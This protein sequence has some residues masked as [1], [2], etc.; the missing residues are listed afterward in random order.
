M[1][2]LSNEIRTNEICIRRGTPVNVLR[3]RKKVNEDRN[4]N[5][6]QTAPITT[7]RDCQSPI[8]NKEIHF[9]AVC[10]EQ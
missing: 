4:S 2:M 1:R 8:S 6:K 3:M 10:S 7:N 5:S 9:S